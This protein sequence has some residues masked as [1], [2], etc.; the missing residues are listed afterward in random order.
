METHRG[1]A[2]HWFQNRHTMKALIT[3][4]DG[5][6]GVDEKRQL[7]ADSAKNGTEAKDK[8]RLPFGSREKRGME[9]YTNL[10]CQNCKNK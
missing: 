2:I 3:H 7:L 8:R 6:L 4:H 1:A 9:A 10:A 5:M